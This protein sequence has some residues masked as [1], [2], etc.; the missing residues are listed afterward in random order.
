M[1]I[2]LDSP[3]LEQHKVLRHIE[4]G[5]G[6]FLFD[7]EWRI[8]VSSAETLK[9]PMKTRLRGFNKYTLRILLQCAVKV[10]FG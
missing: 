3:G 1:K 9:F 4:D 10:V 5:N 7:K 6:N 2:F 8:I